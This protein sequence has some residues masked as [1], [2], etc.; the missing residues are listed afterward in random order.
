ME[1]KYFVVTADTVG[2]VPIGTKSLVCI[3]S[4]SLD[5]NDETCNHTRDVKDSL[6]C[7]CANR[8]LTKKFEKLC[9]T[10]GTP[11]ERD[12]HT[13]MNERVVLQPDGRRATYRFQETYLW[14]ECVCHIKPAKRY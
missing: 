7:V 9:N 1:S 12:H 10:M 13:G 6:Y 3:F 2:L 14:E 8:S 5:E 4:I 11:E